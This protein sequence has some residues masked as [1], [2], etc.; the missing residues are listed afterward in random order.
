MKKIVNRLGVLYFCAIGTLVLMAGAAREA[1]CAPESG[2]SV[3]ILPF[4]TSGPDAGKLG[5]GLPELFA[6]SLAKQGLKVI[7]PKQT[8]Q[9]LRRQ[10]VTDL[11]VKAARNLAVQSR[12]TYAVYGSFTSAGEGFSL[13]TRMVSAAADAAASA[14]PYF[15][16]RTNLIELYPA[17]E[18][19]STAM[20]GDVVNKNALAG[21]QIRG[22][23]VLDPDAILMRLSTSKGDPVDPVAINQEMKRLWDT[24]YFNDISADIE[25]TGEGLMLVFTVAERPRIDSVEVVGSDAVDKKDILEAMSSRTGSVISDKVLAQDLQKITDLYRKKGYYLAEVAYRIE[26][27][28]GTASAR[29]VFDVKEGNR[30]YIKKIAIEGLKTI[31]EDDLKSELALKERGILSWI[32]KT[33]VLREEYLER[34]SAAI[35]AYGLNHGYLNIMVSAPQVKYEED[36]IIVTFAVKEGPRYKIGDITFSGDL[37]D[38][39]ERLLDVITLDEHKD[40]E[41]WMSVSVMQDDGKL[42][43]DFY[44]KYGYTFSEVEPMT[45]QDPDTNVIDVNYRIDKKNK[46]YIRRLTT[47]GNTRTRDNV[48]LREMRMGDGELFDGA[49]LRR[50]N[51]RLHK[52]RYFSEADTVIVPTE[53]EDEVDLQVKV[54]EDQTGAIMGG[55]GYSTYYRFGVSAS[56]SERNLFGRGYSLALAG[57]LSGRSNSL[58]L[59]FTNPRLYDTD[60]GLTYSAYIVEDEWDDFEKKTVGNTISFFYP[61]GEYTTVGLGYRLD[62]YSLF[63]IPETAPRS[64]KEYEGRN[65]S[66]VLSARLVYDSTD[67]KERPSRGYIARAFVEYGGGGIG[68]NDNF[69]KPQMELQ[70]FHTLMGDKDHIIH[71]R[72]RIGAVFENSSKPVPVFDRFFIGGIDSIRGYDSDDISPHDP[73]Y[74]DEIGGDRMGFLNLEYIWTVEPQ[75][76]ISLVPFFD[77]GFENDSKQHSTFSN[78]KKSIGLELRWRSPM[79]DLRFAYGYPLDKSWDGRKLSGRFEFSMGQNF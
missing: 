74:K 39:P 34:D 35:Q 16:Q 55:V 67:S 3:I 69:F 20:A 53:K 4:Q 73:V 63:N 77:I 1:W 68:G 19:L 37:L 42:L 75:L 70:G 41:T 40:K 12:A 59:T 2:A 46:I 27:R 45:R 44:S 13:D 49:K 5:D 62:R 29:L 6:Q 14:R 15:T 76:G 21:V 57:F 28:K 8:L 10:R 54:K 23:R 7:P 52:L 66:S 9:L 78:I 33:G 30:L 47:E 18:E 32:T 65:L 11:D 25:S 24:G 22:L 50:S 79:G 26:E 72:G 48:I 58:D 51:E 60:L 17:V 64:Y 61:I 31:D 36:G 71:W 43:A 56:I 38:T